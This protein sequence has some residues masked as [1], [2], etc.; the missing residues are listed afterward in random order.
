ARISRGK[1]D[2]RRQSTTL[3]E[4]LAA[5]V[6]TAR[7]LI[8]AG[9]HALALR[10]PEQPVRL[11]ADPERLSQIFA[12]LLNNAAKYSDPGGRIE[13]SAEQQDDGIHVHVR[14]TGIGL[15]HEQINGIFELFT[16]VD[17]TTERTRG[18]L[19]IGLTL[20]RQLLDMHG[21]R[22]EARSEGLGAGSEFEVW[23]PPQ[24]AADVSF[25]N[26][27]KTAVAGK[28]CRALVVDD[29]RDSADTLAMMIGLIGHHVRAVY[30]PGEVVEAVRE[31]APDVVFM[32]VGMPGM[33]GLDVA[34]ALRANS[35]GAPLML[36]AVTG[37]G[38]ADDR[39]RTRE[40]GFDQHL[41]K[42]P[43]LEAIR[44]ICAAAAETHEPVS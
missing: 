4:V 5:A 41:V 12:N 11:Q 30:A 20:V 40:S 39:R 10:M 8:D 28:P 22:I 18:G 2:L 31:F 1:L 26:A 14:D 29:N 38:Q 34:R 37:W 9:G 36:V 35:N 13:V 15:T 33:S 43:D 19:G 6:E 27:P 32:D 23:L 3:Q 42:P 21:G 44:S 7:P 17:A 25:F 16:Q 24:D